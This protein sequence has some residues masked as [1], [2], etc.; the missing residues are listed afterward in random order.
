MS[1]KLILLIILFSSRLRALSDLEAQ[2]QA[3]HADFQNLQKLQEEQGGRE[4]LFEELET[5]WKETQRAHSNRW[6]W[7]RGASVVFRC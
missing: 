4:N 2:L 3:H 7:F 6:V 5:Q 1:R